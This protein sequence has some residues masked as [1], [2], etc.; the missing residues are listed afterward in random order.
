MV[1]ASEVLEN[2]RVII[3]WLEQLTALVLQIRDQLTEEG[4]I[5]RQLIESGMA[6]TLIQSLLLGGK[7]S[8]SS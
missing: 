6:D 1:K 5:E 8:D 4:E 3:Q 2:Q 7:G